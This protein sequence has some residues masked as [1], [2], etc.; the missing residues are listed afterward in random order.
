MT[1]TTDHVFYKG[2]VE[3]MT[4]G[5]E[6]TAQVDPGIPI[7]ML[8][9]NPSKEKAFYINGTADLD[10][11]DCAVQV[12][13]DNAL[14]MV[15]NGAGTATAEDFCIRG[16]YSGTN[17]SPAPRTMCATETD[18]LA[19]KFAQDW[20]QTNTT[21]CNYTNVGTI[22]SSGDSD[23][24]EL[25][26]GVYCGGLT[27][28]KGTVHLTSG[29]IY[30]F[31]DGMLDIHA[32]GTVTG[33]DVVILFS[34]NSDTRLNTQAGASLDISAPSTGKFAGIAVAQA[35][36]CVPS[37]ENLIIGG[38]TIE[39]NGILYFRRPFS[40]E[41]DVCFRARTRVAIRE[42]DRSFLPP[43]TENPTTNNARLTGRANLE[44]SL[45]CQARNR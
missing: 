14:A 16:G 29:S 33:D 15:Q 34:G 17:F 45:F 2:L 42:T 31:K 7:C 44:S 37:K 43:K 35:L 20:V 23:I 11:K 1:A 24:T 39:V 5:V 8:V 25:A 18:P 22:N 10:A 32:H 12:N 19:E 30:V 41:G 3:D 4:I 27:V 21:T 36:A 13:S 6:S 38:G 28:K 40:F 9:L 26:P